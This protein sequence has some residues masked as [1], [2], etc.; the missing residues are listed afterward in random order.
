[1]I[2]N[3]RRGLL[4][5]WVVVSAIWV[6]W[7][8]I[9]TYLEITQKR[10]LSDLT[11]PPPP[12]G[13]ELTIELACRPDL[14]GRDGVNYTIEKDG[15]CRYTIN[16]FRSL[17]PEYGDLT[18]SLLM[19]KIRHKSGLL[20]AP[21]PSILPFRAVITLG[22]PAIALALGWGLFWVASGFRGTYP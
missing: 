18:D 5:L 17:Y 20:P 13:F 19:E 7:V 3:L 1:M 21:T 16:T 4:R 14:R 6:S 8:G 12:V 11:I 22:V 10:E 15:V 2:V 9:A